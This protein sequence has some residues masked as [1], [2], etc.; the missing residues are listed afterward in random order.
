MC[1][2]RRSPPER[3]LAPA[4]PGD[5]RCADVDHQQLLVAQLDQR[6]RAD[7]GRPSAGVPT[8][9][10][11]DGSDRMQHHCQFRLGLLPDQHQQ[12]DER[13]AGARRWRRSSR[14]R[15]NHHR[16]RHGHE[17]AGGLSAQSR[18]TGEA[19]EQIDQDVV[20]LQEQQRYEFG[21]RLVS[22]M[23]ENFF[24]GISLIYFLFTCLGCQIL[25]I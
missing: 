24:L 14:R 8:A 23:I 13:H 5:R 7:D 6:G 9:D 12:H 10:R 1:G 15:A 20:P 21:V 17:E 19:G 4:V 3:V 22:L 16:R 25:Y 2:K 18:P 11:R